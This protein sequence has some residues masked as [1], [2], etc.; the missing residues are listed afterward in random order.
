MTSLLYYSILSALTEDEIIEVN[1]RVTN[2]RK[3]VYIF[4]RNFPKNAKDQ[5]K[6]VIR[7]VVFV[8]A[9]WLST[10]R[11]SEAIGSSVPHTQAPRVQINYRTTT[12]K[13]K[14]SP[15]VNP[16]LDKVTFIKY[17]ELPICI[18]M[19]DERFLKTSQASKLIHTIRVVG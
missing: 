13:L 2:N 4:V 6:K 8:V 10:L 5:T 17:R 7:T 16:K 15:A 11:P 19:M 3:V 9:V 12:H 14:V 18:Y 1:H